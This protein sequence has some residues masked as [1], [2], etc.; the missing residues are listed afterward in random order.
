MQTINLNIDMDS[1]MINQSLQPGDMVYYV[2]MP[3]YGVDYY[4]VQ[5]PVTGGQV[6]G[7]DVSANSANC[8]QIG[9]VKKILGSILVCNIDES[10]NPPQPGDFIF[11]SKNRSVNEASI[12]GYYGKFRFKNNSRQKAELFSANCNVGISS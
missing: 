6:G 2:S 4:G 9:V 10:I 12:V 3:S 8:I 11:F 7:F 1:S 5:G